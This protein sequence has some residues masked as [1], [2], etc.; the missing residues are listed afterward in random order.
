MDNKFVIRKVDVRQIINSLVEMWN[1][2][3]DFVDIHAI[4]EPEQDKVVLSAK[5]EYMCERLEED[6][7]IAE[8]EPVKE[9][10]SEAPQQGLTNDIINQL[11]E[12]DDE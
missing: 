9:E 11:L 12:D 8:E 6:K 3:A 10:E 7:F 1:F 4:M 5:E 2:G